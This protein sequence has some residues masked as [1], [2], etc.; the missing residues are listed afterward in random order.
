MVIEKGSLNFISDKLRPITIP[1]FIDRVIQKAITKVLEA[2]LE[3]LNR[4]FGFRPNKGVHGA[5]IGISSRLNI[6]KRIA[7]ERDIKA[8]YDK[9]DKNILLYV[10]S[11]RIQDRKFLDLIKERLD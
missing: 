8:V 10:L 2:E 1:P 11:K 4:L 9:V 5:I 3:F 7:I 6:G